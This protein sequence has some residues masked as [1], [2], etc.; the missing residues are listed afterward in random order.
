MDLLN[1]IKGGLPFPHASI[2]PVPTPDPLSNYAPVI[3]AER[4]LSHVEWSY[5]LLLALPQEARLG[6][7]AHLGLPLFLHASAE[8][9]EVGQRLSKLKGDLPD[10]FYDEIVDRG[11]SA[12]IGEEG[13][14]LWLRLSPT[15]N[16]AAGNVGIP[17]LLAL[18]DA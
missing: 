18:M 8:V 12:D 5:Q 3:L 15:V 16:I 1:R 11:Y 2:P 7:A 9:P 17:G 13:Y 10:A 14:H 6:L 4:F